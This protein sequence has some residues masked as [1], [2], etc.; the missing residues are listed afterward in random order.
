[1]SK[2]QNTKPEDRNGNVLEMVLFRFIPYWP[3]FILLVICCSA[4]AWLYLKY[5]TPK[6]QAYAKI[7]LNDEKKG[8]DDS[9]LL[10]SLNIY[11]SKKIVENEIEV[12]SS[13]TLMKE[14][15]N[16][17]HLYAPV[18]QQGGF[19]DEVA[20]ASSPVVIELRDPENLKSTDAVPF[21]YDQTQRTVTIGNQ[22]YGLDKWVTT[23]YGTLKFTE[24]KNAYEAATRPLYFTLVEPNVM[25]SG[26]LG[27][28]EV[29]P[30]NKASTVLTL[31][32]K[33]VSP[34]RARDILNA[35]MESYSQS[36]ISEKNAL[37]NN[38]LKFIDDRL[39]LVVKDLE[40]IERKIQQ[41][42]SQQGIVDLSE[43]SKVF[44]QHVG[45]ND[46]KVTDINMKLAMLDEVEQ[47]V[48]KNDGSSIAPA[49][50]GLEDGQLLKLLQRHHD[51]EQEYINLRE[52]MGEN[53][54]ALTALNTEI[55]K[56]K[57]AILETV[58]NL[59]KNLQASRTNLSTT[60]GAYTSMLGSIPQKERELLEI[61]RQQSIKNSVYSFLL[62][63]REETALSRSSTVSDSRLIDA[64]EASFYPVSPNRSFAF[65]VAIVLGIAIS[66][67]FVYAKEMLTRKILFRSDIER[68]TKVPVVA[69]IA[70]VKH[71]GELVVNNASKVFIAE[72]FRQLRAAIG[73]YGRAASKKRILI[74]S[75]IQGEGKS[76][77]AANLAQSLALSGK[78]V[79]L[80][81]ADLRSPKTSSIFELGEEPGMTEYLQGELNLNVLVKQSGTGNLFVVP[82]GGASTSPTELLINGRLGDLF[83][84][85]ENTYDYVLI[86]T[87]PID[88]VTDAYVLSE[89]SDRTLFVI[90]HAFTPKAMVQLLDE[91]SK[92]KALHNPS[93]VF[94]GIKKRGFLK[95]SYGFG[96]GF[97]YAYVYKERGRVKKEG[98]KNIM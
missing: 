67:G 8:A 56:L 85:L 29:S 25:A 58:R 30:T 84:Y 80:V 46:R 49:T 40:G 1:M 31:V 14:V 23:P 2:T 28:L 20:Y 47:A 13:R 16:K 11:G 66:A 55:G 27:G 76:F 54:P 79:V 51:A 21:T 10:E 34:Y 92:I 39:G 74:T 93:I 44:L 96:H 65:L 57:P 94:N 61:S 87:S 89:Y 70:S 88:P 86:D 68:Y 95:G 77:V 72:Q 6:F 42:K 17:L 69:E 91:S 50:L 90:R 62:Q 3:L 71:R 35:L 5:A 98:S 64:A 45:E 81:D 48:T 52:T 82:A 37:A 7:L 18:Y 43:Q 36:T 22:A 9:R 60:T 41:Y 33:D 4:G 75:S 73:L 63:K 26:L 53:S 15:V 59:R 19:K 38:T 24:N 78:K 32:Y 12:I 83:A 97:G